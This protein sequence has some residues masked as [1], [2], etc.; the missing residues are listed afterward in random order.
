MKLVSSRLSRGFTLIELVVVLM[1]LALVTHLAVRELGK[2]QRAR[3]GQAANAQLETVRDAVWR[4]APGEEPTGFLVDL[5]RL[6]RAARATNELGRVVGTLAE[7]W[8]RPADVAPFAFRP[9]VESNLV[10]AVA[11][12]AAL[13]DATVV[14][15]C[16]WRGP[17]VR[18]PFGRDRLLDAWGNPLETPDDAGYA[19]LLGVDGQAAEVGTPVARVRHFGADGRPDD[20]VEPPDAAARDV[21]VDLVPEGRLANPLVVN[22]SF[23]SGANPSTVDG[24]A[25]CRWYM[26]CGGAITGGVAT[27][28]LAGVAQTSFAFEGLPPGMCTLAVDV[29]GARRALERVVVPPGG[30]IVDVKVAVE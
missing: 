3:L 25:R 23:V 4:T 16:G 18:L 10:A 21:S 30:R 11:E 6:P 29:G 5:G 27:A 7:L 1:V 12:K 19:R 9:A 24:T 2:V 17:Y 14:V 20:A 15:P 8:E 22:A 26:P 28:T 13:V